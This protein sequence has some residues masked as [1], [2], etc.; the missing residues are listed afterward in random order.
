MLKL[1]PDKAIAVA[2]AASLRRWE[3]S[4]RV[5]VVWA[6]DDE[7]GALLLEAIAC[8]TPVSETQGEVSLLRVAELIG[9]LHHAAEPRVG[10]GIVPLAER[11]DF[12]FE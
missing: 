7:T 3:P 5:P 4:C 10:N 9:A 6:Y 12:V 2:E 8:E 1:T 11:V